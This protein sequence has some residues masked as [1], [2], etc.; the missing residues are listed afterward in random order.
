MC[1]DI[2]VSTRCPHSILLMHCGLYTFPYA[3]KNSLHTS[4]SAAELTP[5]CSI[6]HLEAEKFRLGIRSTLNES[7]SLMMIFSGA[8][9]SF[10]I[11]GESE[12]SRNK[13]YRTADH[14]SQQSGCFFRRSVSKVIACTYTFHV[15]QN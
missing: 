1:V 14:I 9:I 6:L 10:N 13:F 11:R 12:L 4:I 5:R 7:R 8:F 15:Q 2:I 3:K